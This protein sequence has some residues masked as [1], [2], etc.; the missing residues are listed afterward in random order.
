[1]HFK[2]KQPIIQQDNIDA[3]IIFVVFAWAIKQN[4]V[5]KRHRQA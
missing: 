4:K 1:M 2:L 3:N 5:N